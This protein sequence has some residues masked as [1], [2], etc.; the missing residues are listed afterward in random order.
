[1]TE[2]KRNPRLDFFIT[3]VQQ[4]VERYEQSQLTPF[5]DHLLKT[6]FD[7]VQ[8]HDKLENFYQIC[9]VIPLL[10]AKNLQS[11][12]YLYQDEGKIFQLVC[13][14]E[15]GLPQTPLTVKDD[16]LHVIHTSCESNDRFILPIFSRS[17]GHTEKQLNNNSDS[18]QDDS[19]AQCLDLYLNPRNFLGLFVISPASS[20]SQ[21][22]RFFLAK[23]VNRIGY[24]LQRRLVVANHLEHVHFLQNLGTD[25]GHNIIT[26]NMHFKYLFRQLA[27]K[28]TAIDG[29]M[30]AAQDLPDQRSRQVFQRC[31]AIRRELGN[32]HHQLLKHYNRTSLY[33]ETLLREEH[34]AKGH[35]VLKTRECLV[36]RDIILP[37]LEM[38]RNRLKQRGISIDR[39]QNMV[40]LRFPLVVDVGLLSQVYANL[41]SNA[42]KYTS[43]ITTTTGMP[44]KAMAYGCEK[45]SHFPDKLTNGVKFN[46]FST[47]PHLAEEERATLFEEGFRGNNIGSNTGSGHGLSFVRNVVE[48]HGGEVGYEAVQEGNNFYFILP[49]P[50]TTE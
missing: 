48:I 2:R 5:H 33:L 46:V 45:V 3:S 31:R 4:Q 6:F 39:P 13:D 30:E 17:P 43:E 12:F 26:P 37:E 47:G 23:L 42:V 18:K 50:E 8:R 24:N 29:E 40:K 21:T 1:M 44:R 20:L 25:I 15:Q 10:L 34:F 49:L 35:L 22:D 14:S 19:G 9:I 41:F 38:Y 16:F 28:I 32:C 27:K 7:L 11:N 36:E